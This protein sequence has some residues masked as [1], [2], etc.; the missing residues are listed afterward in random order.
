MPEADTVVAKEP[1]K[2]E[3]KQ[4]RRAAFRRLVDMGK[5]E[6]ARI[7]VGLTALAVNS[8]TNLS[9]PW[10]L[11]QAVDRAGEENYSAFVTGAAGVF[12]VGSLASWVRVYCLGTSTERIASRIR[13]L[14]FNSYMEKDV[15]FFESSSSG[16]LM[17]VL[18]KDVSTAAEM[19]TEKLAGGLRSLNSSFNGS[20]VLFSIAPQLC[21]VSLA[22]VPV[23]GIGA[24]TLSKYSRKL[25]EK[26]R[27]LETSMMSFALERVGG[28][29]TVRLN[30][31]EE[32]EKARYGDYTDQCYELSAQAHYAQG[33]FMSFL[34]VATNASLLAVLFVG[35]G[36]IAR[37]K[38]TA[39][40]LTRFA[41]TSV[42]VGLGF[43]GLSTAHGDMLRSLDA[44]DRIFQ[45]VD[46]GAAG[47]AKAQAKAASVAVVKTATAETKSPPSLVLDKVVF[48]HSSRT[49]PVLRGLSLRI[50]GFGLTAVVGKSGAGKS[51]LLSLLCGL[52]RPSSGAVLLD[53]SQVTD[54][55]RGWLQSKC[56]VVEQ[57]VGLFSGSVRDNIA[58][59]V[60]PS[61][62]TPQVPIEDVVAAAKAAH[63]H[64]FISS[65]PE[66]YETPVGEGG[67]R[68]SGGQSARVAIAR[69]VI[70]SPRYLLLD[71]A[72]AALDQENEAEIVSLLQGLAVSRAVVVFT[73]SEALMK[74]AARVV[75][76]KDGAA[77][78][79]GTYAELK[80]AGA[81]DAVLCTKV[82]RQ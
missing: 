47:Q 49:D 61:S 76:L 60:I 62:E 1:T 34:N 41:M 29:S 56:G 72:T 79:S 44:A 55:P 81:L 17:T 77:A 52:L 10:I 45:V 28:I 16:E 24:M 70:R 78:H 12:L 8:A 57:R 6:A 14:I 67:S 26:A 48:S 25:R 73:H 15:E 35:G 66:G 68:L 19:L 39:G 53:G 30:G 46:K 75:V 3:L 27:E 59:G 2:A 43:S 13:K 58:Y 38:M 65:F 69:A 11:G 31:Q 22:M 23:V 50:E 5:P 64:D 21:G 80:T 32:R 37:G 82:E 36:L 18:D 42:F 71:E 51:T 40:S 33:G 74:G 9:F 4:R 20:I 63:A 7:A 54:M